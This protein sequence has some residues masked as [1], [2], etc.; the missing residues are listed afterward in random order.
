MNRDDTN[1]DIFIH[2][3][4]V[5]KNNPNKYKKSVGENEKVEFDIVQ[6]DK[7]NEATNVTGPNGEPVI[8]SKYAAEKKQRKSRYSRNRR[9]TNKS[10]NGEQGGDKLQDASGS[11]AEN[12]GNDQQGGAQQGDNEGKPRIKRF[13]NKRPFRR[14]KSANKPQDGSQGGE[15]PDAVTNTNGG[16]AG[17]DG[18]QQPPRHRRQNYNRRRI[19]KSVDNNINNSADLGNGSEPNSGINNNNNE[20]RPPRPRSY[21]NGQN[22]NNNN[23]NN[24]VDG[25]NRRPPHFNRPRTY[26]P[27]P[28]QEQIFSPNNMIDQQQQQQQ[29]QPTGLRNQGPVGGQF[30]P[31]GNHSN[32]FS[33]N[34]NFNTSGG[35]N[36]GG[37]RG[38]G[39]M[40]SSGGGGG[41]GYPRG[42]GNFRG[43]FYRGGSRGSRNYRGNNNSYSENVIYKNVMRHDSFFFNFS[44]PNLI[45]NNLVIK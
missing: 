31:R 37:F 8:G 32:H 45:N 23:N 9:R 22:F 42:G 3:S 39:Q 38:N 33:N 20:Q 6:G 25:N 21:N 2:Q 36:G 26:R 44:M 1:E 35:M 19:N 18:Q 7:G 43:G 29:Q 30:I 28:P 16:E 11:A 4:A 27:R 10:E 13:R 14:P 17:P 24:N 34:N 15:N 41:R 40:G 12:S 5:A